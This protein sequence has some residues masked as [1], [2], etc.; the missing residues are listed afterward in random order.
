[1]ADEARQQRWRS[2]WALGGKTGPSPLALRQL[3]EPT[4][5]DN[6]SS[7]RIATACRIVC[8]A[9][10]MLHLINRKAARILALERALRFLGKLRK[11]LGDRLRQRSKEILETQ[12]D[13]DVLTLVEVIKRTD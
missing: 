13:P 9:C 12:P 4:T 10:R 1:V 11:N 6:R 2:L 8:L 3:V 5:W 7:G